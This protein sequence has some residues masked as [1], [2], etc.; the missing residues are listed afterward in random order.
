MELL[1]SFGKCAISNWVV[2]I[3][4]GKYKNQNH[5]YLTFQLVPWIRHFLTKCNIMNML[6]FGAEDQKLFSKDT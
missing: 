3:H 6:H 1:K 4:T 5:F 2:Q